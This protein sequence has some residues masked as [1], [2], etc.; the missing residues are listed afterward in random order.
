VEEDQPPAGEQEPEHVPDRRAGARI[1]ATNH[2]LPEWP[3]REDPDAQRRHPERDRD[4]EDEHDQ[5]RYGV[6]DRHPQA[7]EDEPD[8][9]EEHSHPRVAS[10]T[11][12]NAR[13]PDLAHQSA[14][15]WKYIPLRRSMMRIEETLYQALVWLVFEPKRCRPASTV[16]NRRICDVVGLVS[17][18]G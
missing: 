18:D 2:G 3:E 13:T 11:A 7:R 5:R 17:S 12:A 16:A 4:D 15:E 6:A 14:P 1:R 8:H 10:H 9:V